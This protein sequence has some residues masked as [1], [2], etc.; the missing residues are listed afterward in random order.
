MKK[1]IV[2]ATQLEI[3][4]FLEKYNTQPVSN[5][6]FAITDTV[7]C[8]LTGVGML[9]TV[10]ALYNIDINAYDLLIQVGVAGTYD[11][12]LQIGSMVE[13]VQ[14]QL[15]DLGAESAE[16]DFLTIEDLAIGRQEVYKNKGVFDLP[17][18]SAIT[19]QVVAG[20]QHTIDERIRLFLPDVETMEGFAFAKFCSV[21]QLAY[22]QV[23]AISNRVEVRNREQWDMKLA[24]E[25][26]HCFLLDV[27]MA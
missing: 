21:H 26:L 1:L 24:L 11:D 14:E 20:T 13:V 10:F 5:E 4:L 9:N 17:V 12:S 7:D 23:R 2:A 16:G 15:G 3:G 22:A 18:V 6:A 27:I 8:L 19:V 25:R